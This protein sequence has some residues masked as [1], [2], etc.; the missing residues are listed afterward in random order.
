MPVKVPTAMNIS[1]RGQSRRPGARG[2]KGVFDVPL[3]KTIHAIRD[4][5]AP[6]LIKRKEM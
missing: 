6:P 5:M 2:K 1:A 3:S 4:A